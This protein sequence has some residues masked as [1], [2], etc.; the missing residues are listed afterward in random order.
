MH[1][2]TKFIGG[3]GNSIGGV[4]VDCGTY[5][6]LGAKHRYKTLVEPNASYN[7]MKLAE[8]F[9]NFAFAIAARVMGLR[10]LGPAIS[11]MNA[12]LHP[13]RHRDAAAAH[14][15]PLRERA[16]RRKLAREA[17]EGGVGQL[18]RAAV[19]QRYHALQKKIAPRAPARCS[20]SA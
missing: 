17:P 19:E 18:R 20:P 3:H 16:R 14:G 7:G 1:S 13:H 4:I 10:D 8:T 5:D 2:L 11:P 6:W 15:A 9:G 12:F